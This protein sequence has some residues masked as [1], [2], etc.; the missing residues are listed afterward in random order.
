MPADG[1]ALKSFMD[2]SRI[3]PV[4]VYESMGISKQAFYKLYKSQ[5]FE[6]DTINRLEKA[7]GKKWDE[8]KALN[9]D[10]SDTEGQPSPE[11]YRTA[12]DRAIFNLTESNR[13]MAEAMLRDAISRENDSKSR[14]GLTENNKELVRMVE[15]K[16]TGYAQ[17]QSQQDVNAMRSVFLELLFEIGSGKLRLKS[18]DEGRAI[19]RKRIA[20]ALAEDSS[21][22]TQKNSG[23]KRKVA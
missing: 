14:L 8:V 11:P 19:Y 20:A 18:V 12:T 6:Q 15:S 16:F 21:E 9:V 1:P 17:E 23:K 13:M 7:I 22:D 4:R 10:L 5:V 3:R 2:R